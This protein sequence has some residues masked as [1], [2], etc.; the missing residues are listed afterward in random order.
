[1]FQYGLR[2]YRKKLDYCTTSLDLLYE[3]FGPLESESIT[4]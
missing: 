3:T 2:Y 4:N 1:M